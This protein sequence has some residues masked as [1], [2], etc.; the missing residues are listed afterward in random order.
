MTLVSTSKASSR[1]LNSLRIQTT[2]RP[3]CCASRIRLGV[4]RSG[5]ARTHKTP[6]VSPNWPY[7][8]IHTGWQSVHGYKRAQ[9]GVVCGN[10]V[11][12]LKAKVEAWREEARRKD[13]LLAAALER[14]PALEEPREGHMTAS[15]DAG[16]VTVP[17]DGRKGCAAASVVE[18]MVRSGDMTKRALEAWIGKHVAV[19]NPRSV[20]TILPLAAGLRR[21]AARVHPSA[22]ESSTPAPRPPP[23]E[24]STPA[25]GAPRQ[26]PK[27]LRELGQEAL[28]GRL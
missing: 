6:C 14:I 10:Q 7:T 19:L 15:E 2:W 23:D 13:Y 9:T 17:P 3:I 11:S 4:R 22:D 27:R 21:S 20:G 5:R 28:F 1:Y 25:H 26:A 18:A 24:V 16:K 12:Y 8:C